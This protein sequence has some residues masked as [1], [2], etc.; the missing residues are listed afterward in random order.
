[1]ASADVELPVTLS[2]W[3]MVVPGLKPSFLKTS[4]YVC[5]SH[6]TKAVAATGTSRSAT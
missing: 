3:E 2:Q 6:D 5:T 1:M 4:R